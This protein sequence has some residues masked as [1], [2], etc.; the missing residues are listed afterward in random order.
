MQSTPMALLTGP[1]EALALDGVPGEGDDLATVANG[2][3]AVP[4]GHVEGADGAPL[5]APG[6]AGP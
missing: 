5:R 6:G 4:G 1:P 3:D 2:R